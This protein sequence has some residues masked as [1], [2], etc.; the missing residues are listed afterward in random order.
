MKKIAIALFSLSIL[1][2]IIVKTSLWY[3]THD[4]VDTQINN[5]KPFLQISYDKISSSFTGSATVHDIKVYIPT[6]DETLSI[7]SVQFKAAD[8]SSLLSLNSHLNNNE[9]PKS[10]TL[11][12]KGISLSLSGKIVK[13]LDDPTIEPS[14][15]EV[16]STLA[17]GNTVRIGSK[18]L[19]QMGYQ[20]FIDDMTLTYQFDPRNKVVNY[21][22]KN[23]FRDFIHFNFYGT[24]NNITNLNSLKTMLINSSMVN[25]AKLGDIAVEF[26][27]DSYVGRKNVFCANQ[28][29]RKV[30]DYINEH[31]LQVKQYLVSYG[32]EAEDGLLDAYRTSLEK[33]GSILFEANLSKLS[34]TTELMSFEPNDFIQFVRLKLFVNSK[35]INE[36][37]INI[38]KEQLI[39]A[40]TTKEVELETPDQIKEKK[41]VII[42][43]YRPV[44]VANLKNFNGFKVIIENSKGAIYKGNINTK[45]ADTYEVITRLR[46]GSISYH[47]PISTIKSAKVFH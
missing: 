11:L 47:I 1:L 43:K 35:R 18:E 8:L 25:S 33:P 28:G 4:F 20:S 30:E 6:K 17:C 37:S 41:A 23:H 42:R 34:G 12:I 21:D 26:I 2:F 40:T 32:V 5:A 29:K 39:R 14:H 46:S 36:I 3:F 31:S 7:E 22:I 27:D 9:L 44:S 24:I 38:D 15:L 13:T 10:L 19:T 45:E 16:F